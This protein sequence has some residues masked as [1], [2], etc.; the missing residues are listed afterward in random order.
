L[1][2]LGFVQEDKESVVEESG[3]VEV[4]ADIYGQWTD[5]GG[6]AT[7]N[8]NDVLNQMQDL[9][10]EKGNLFQIPPY[11]GMLL[12]MCRTFERIVSM[13]VFCSYHQS[14]TNFALVR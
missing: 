13:L 9:A 7:I 4:L 2:L 5:G 11:F 12:Q 6:L 14:H 10:A 8:A 3:V 1:Y